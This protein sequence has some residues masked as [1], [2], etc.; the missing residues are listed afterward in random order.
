M[1]PPG[2]GNFYQTE[3]IYDITTQNG[4]I[5]GYPC[6]KTLTLSS[7]GYYQ[8]ANPQVDFGDDIYV[9]DKIIEYMQDGFYIE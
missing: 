3:V 5:N 7:D 1:V 6:M 4:S 8:I 2:H 9:K